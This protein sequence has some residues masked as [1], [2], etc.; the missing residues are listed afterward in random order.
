MVRI[1]VVPFDPK[2]ATREE[3]TRF[4]RFRR[5]RHQETDPD[6]PLLADATVEARKQQPDTDWGER[7]FAVVDE[8]RPGEWV[9]RLFL[10]FARPGTATFDENKHILWSWAAL[11]PEYRRRGIGHALIRKVARYAREHDKSVVMSYAEEESGLAFWKGVGARDALRGRQSRLEM[12]QV[13]WTMVEAWVADGPARSP[14]SRLQWYTG[15]IDEEDLEEWSRAFTEV[16]NMMPRDDLD[17]GDEVF[18]PER[19]RN[20]EASLVKAGATM[21]TAVTLETD[22]T[23]SGL[24][25]MGYFPEEDWMIH[26]WMTGVRRPYRGRGLGK[27]LKA[28]MLLRVREEFPQVRVVLTG[29]AFSNAPMLSINERLGFKLYREGM[30]VQIPLEDLETYLKTAPTDQGIGVEGAD[31]AAEV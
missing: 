28:A 20:D 14:S 23:I 18:T 10:E 15:R 16:W 24:T 27:W 26:Q 11:L 2:R 4:H 22:G 1:K 3:W 6:D 5:I 7:E 8:D 9:G 19:R 21:L 13:D 31:E 17:M 30:E 12:D 29:N 25:E